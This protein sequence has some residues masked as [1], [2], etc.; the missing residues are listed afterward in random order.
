MPKLLRKNILTASVVSKLIYC[1]LILVFIIFGVIRNDLS[2]RAFFSGINMLAWANIITAQSVDGYRLPDYIFIAPYSGKQREALYKKGFKNNLIAI[3]SGLFFIIIL[4]ILFYS[5]A[6][7]M[8]F[9]SILCAVEALFLFSALYFTQ[10]CSY[11]FAKKAKTVYFIMFVEFMLYSFFA[12]VELSEKTPADTQILLRN[13]SDYTFDIIIIL[14]MVVISVVLVIVCYKKY[15]WELVAINAD[16]ELSR[17][18]KV[19]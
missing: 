3:Y 11:L 18:I 16:Y 2:V 14:C 10:C 5:I 6:K 4:P 13:L 17:Q 9:N 12:G 1:V 19:K 7:G 15:F 8:L